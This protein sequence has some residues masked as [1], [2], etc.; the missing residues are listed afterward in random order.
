MELKAYLEREG[1]SV[2]EFARR[3]GFRSRQV[4]HGYLAGD[5]FPTPEN[6]RRIREATGGA[7]TADDF[8]DQ[9]TSAPTPTSEAAA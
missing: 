7:V 9:H 8:V 3:A 2:A 6:L 4:I 5:R 1:L